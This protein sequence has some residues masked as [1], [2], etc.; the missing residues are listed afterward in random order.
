MDTTDR[1]FSP[2]RRATALAP[3]QQELELPAKAETIVPFRNQLGQ[4]LVPIIAQPKVA[5]TTAQNDLRLRAWMA[6]SKLFAQLL[7][8]R[9]S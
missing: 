2:K 5:E 3:A 6:L 7:P 4:Q 1:M 9:P 8:Q